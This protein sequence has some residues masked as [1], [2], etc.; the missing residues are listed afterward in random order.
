[1]GVF[2][3]RELIF[4]EDS[5]STIDL[6]EIQKSTDKETLVDTSTQ[7]EETPI[8]PL[9]NHYLFVDL[10]DLVCYPSFMDII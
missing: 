3:K 8:F 4:R 1:M 10:L 2:R 5:E 6:K 7:H 9:T